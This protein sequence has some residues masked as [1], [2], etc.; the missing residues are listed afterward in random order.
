MSIKSG[1]AAM[2]LMASM[3]SLTAGEAPPA[4]KALAAARVMTLPAD[5]PRAQVYPDGAITAGDLFK[6][7]KRV[8]V[9]V[10]LNGRGLLALGIYR[11][12]QGDWRPALIEDLTSDGRHYEFAGEWPVTFDDLDGDDKPELLLTEA[13]EATGNR[14]VSIYTYDPKADTFAVA[15]RG[16]VNPRW[17]AGEVRSTWKAGATSGDGILESWRWKDGRLM[18]TW[19]AGQRYPMHEY[20]IGS[21]EPAVRV[22]YVRY[23]EGAIALSLTALGNVASFRNDL[24]RGEPPRPMRV[25]VVVA[26]GLR[27]LV[28]TPKTGALT[29]AKL[30]SAWDE[31]VSR[32][33][34]SDAGP[35]PDAM[36]TLADGR[37]AVLSAVATVDSRPAGVGPTYQAF[38]ISDEL[39]MTFE[40][41]AK[42][43]VVAPC[44]AHGIDWTRA[45]Q[46][47][48][49]YATGINAGPSPEIRGDDDVLLALRLPNVDGLTPSEV[50]Q[51][52][53]V[54]TLT[55]TDGQ[56]KL[57]LTAAVPQPSGLAKKSVVRP[58]VVVSLGRLAPGL[59]RI[60]ASIKGW[61]GG[62]LAAKGPFRV[63]PEKK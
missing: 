36:V 41:P 28:I 23:D 60:E 59:W 32:A 29:A 6:Q 15:A 50:E 13:Q 17:V 34:L 56:V 11:H 53:R 51:A 24:P 49:A 39:R 4:L 14:T 46:A 42:L 16:L 19:H 57:D 26:D 9:A 8:A 47:I 33:M 5:K 35:A 48:A 22:S 1:I 54:V 52:L 43:P 7:G 58:L 31:L 38:S 12:R 20:L 10:A 61:T 40:E 2:M 18:R 45:E 55:A 63:T 3:P 27:D 37:T 62:D 44:S 21:G 30:D 25:Q